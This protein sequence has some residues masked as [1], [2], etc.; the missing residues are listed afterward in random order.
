MSIMINDPYTIALLVLASAVAVLN[1]AAYVWTVDYLVLCWC[2]FSAF[3]SLS[4]I[5][6]AVVLHEG[7]TP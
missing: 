5:A 1:I 6:V 3:L 7:K 4:I 2:L